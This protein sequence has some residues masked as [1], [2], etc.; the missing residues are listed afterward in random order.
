[1]SVVESKVLLSGMILCPVEL[2][3]ESAKAAMKVIKTVSLRMM[4][5]LF[6]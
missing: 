3:E 1:L 2:Q 6:R 4:I 5:Y